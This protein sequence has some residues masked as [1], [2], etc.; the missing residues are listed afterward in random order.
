MCVLIFK[1]NNLGQN[2]QKC[3][4]IHGGQ[5]AG[6]GLQS[7]ITLTLDN[8]YAGDTSAGNVSIIMFELGDEH[9]GGLKLPNGEVSFLS[10]FTENQWL[11]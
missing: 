2:L 11:R 6:R 4:G 10:R 7:G 8:V 9:L 1:Q 3:I 5:D